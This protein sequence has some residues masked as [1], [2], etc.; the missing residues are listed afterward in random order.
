MKKKLYILLL[1]FPLWGL[2]GL[3]C[4]NDDDNNTQDPLSQLPLATQTGENT[5]GCLVNGEPF[6]DSGLMNN[7]YQFVNGE[8]VLAIN[9][10][11]G[12]TGN[13][14]LG[15][16]VL[17]NT[18]INEEEIYILN[19]SNF[20]ENDYTGGGALF[21][22]DIKLEEGQY[23]TN[24]NFTGQIYFTRFDD[25]NNIMSGTFSFE[26]EEINTGEIIT[27]TAGRFDL[28]FTN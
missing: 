26:A 16:I 18:Q 27:I 25:E 28:T 3:S 15:Q 14:R 6:T 22:T 23:E 20:L 24:H 13:V 12:F 19:K 7:F 17:R 11:K 9:W 1:L 2:G 5:I 10:E 21:F 8:S 4:N